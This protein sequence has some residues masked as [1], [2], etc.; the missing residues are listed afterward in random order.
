MEIKKI[1][2]CR[3]ADG[4]FVGVSEKRTT[5]GLFDK[6]AEDVDFLQ[7]GLMKSFNRADIDQRQDYI[8]IYVLSY[9]NK[10]VDGNG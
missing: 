6:L 1:T 7:Q 4:L 5:D 8:K 9:L 3:Q 2:L 10:I